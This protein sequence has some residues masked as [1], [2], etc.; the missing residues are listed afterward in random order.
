M[1][2]ALP[3]ACCGKEVS[4]EKIDSKPTLTRWLR[5]LRLVRGQLF[6]LR[7]A[8]DHGYDFDRHEC[9]DCYGPGYAEM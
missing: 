5:F 3:C 2:S 7:Y 1:N 9:A 4:I 8:G 6:M